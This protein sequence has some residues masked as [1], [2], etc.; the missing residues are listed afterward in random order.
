M[1]KRIECL[2]FGRVQ[3]VMYRDFT[4]RNARALG[5]TGI[6]KNRDDGSVSV[7]AEG[8]ESALENFVAKLKKGPILASVERVELAWKEATRE[9]SDFCIVYK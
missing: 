3:M 4:T 9:F 8:E 7:I 2:V 6:V 5:L 1:Q